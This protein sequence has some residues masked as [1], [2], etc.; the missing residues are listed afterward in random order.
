[1]RHKLLGGAGRRSAAQ[2]LKG[3]KGM[4]KKTNKGDAAQDPTQL[5]QDVIPIR[6]VEGSF[7]RRTDGASILLVFIEGT[8]D[9]LYTYDQKL[10][11]S[12]A[13]RHALVALNR[14]FS[15]IKVPKTIDSNMQLVH[16]DREIAQ[17]RQE[18][19]EAGRTI[20]DAHPKAIRLRLLEDRLRPKA[21]EEA[22]SGD[23]VIHPTYIAIEFS[24]KDDDR[25]ALRDA[26]IFVDR[27]TETERQAHI[28]SFDEVIEALQLYFTPRI[29][30][31]RAVLGNT[32]VS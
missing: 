19:R 18:I 17:L 24:A 7:V 20:S 5:A 14:P 6:T 22:T 4:A 16:I 11:E 13:N 27:V 28:C 3:I 30:S 15:I 12:D 9:S 21:E 26:K 32:P 23:R 1:M 29:V 25:I 31:P 10:E 8:N 2:A